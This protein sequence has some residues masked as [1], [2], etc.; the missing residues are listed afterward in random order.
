[1]YEY[2]INDIISSKFV[3]IGLN[4]ALLKDNWS[5]D[6]HI[7]FFFLKCQMIVYELKTKT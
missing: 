1:M 3:G 5:G 6:P 7:F 4:L 2:N